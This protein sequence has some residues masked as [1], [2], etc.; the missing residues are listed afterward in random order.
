M[1]AKPPRPNEEPYAGKLLVRFR[2]GL[3]RRLPSLLDKTIDRDKLCNELDLL[4]LMVKA[5][6]QERKLDNV[7]VSCG[8]QEQ[9]WRVQHITKEMG[10]E[11]EAEV[12]KEFNIFGTLLIACMNLDEITD[13]DCKILIRQWNKVSNLCMKIAY[14]GSAKEEAKTLLQAVEKN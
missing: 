8:L 11:R 7:D 2:E 4:E 14:P 1:K 9:I 12:C 5:E 13:D 3:G 10:G 6:W